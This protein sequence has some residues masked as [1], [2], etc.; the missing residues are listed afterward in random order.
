MIVFWGKLAGLT[1]GIFG[2]VLG[3]VFGLLVGHLLDLVAAEY[4]LRQF[5]AGMAAGRERRSPRG[6]SRKSALLALTVAGV[7][8][9]TWRPAPEDREAFSRGARDWDPA[10][11]RFLE[12]GRVRYLDAALAVRKEIAAGLLCEQITT[13]IPE[14]ERQRLIELCRRTLDVEVRGKTLGRLR[15]LA[16]EIGL[17]DE[18]IDSRLPSGGASGAVGPLDSEVCRILGVEPDTD[19]TEVRR[20][21]RKLAAQFHPD[22]TAG[23]TDDQRQQSAAAFVTI[24]DAYDRAMRQLDSDR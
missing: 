21:Y 1:L 7:A 9:P 6:L 17:S 20:V 22:T 4:L 10:R 24:R 2:G 18:W 8:T 13:T 15:G 5:I 12:R 11:W 23:L 16:E 3:V 14:A 19:I